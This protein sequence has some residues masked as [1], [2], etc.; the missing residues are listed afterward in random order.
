V[1]RVEIFSIFI[2]FE[3]IHNLWFKILRVIIN[4]SKWFFIYCFLNFLLFII[5]IIHLF[6][7]YFLNFLWIQY[8]VFPIKYW[9][10][11]HIF[12]NPSIQYFSNTNLEILILSQWNN[13]HKYHPFTFE[14]L[15]VIFYLYKKVK[16]ENWF[17]P[18]IW[19]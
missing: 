8:L 15:R 3:A 4:L 10:P 7:I 1:W 19:V 5:R 9:L 14:Y 17:L 11:W 6:E 13:I 16:L 12:S 18:Y 2:S